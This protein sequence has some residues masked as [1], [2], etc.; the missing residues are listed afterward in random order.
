MSS[1]I[2]I[3]NG[4]S[5]DNLPLLTKIIS[6][7]KSP[8]FTN[9]SFL[10]AIIGFNAKIT[11]IIKSELSKYLKNIKLLIIFLYISII[12]LFLNAK[13]KLSIISF[14]SFVSVFNLYD[15]NFNILLKS[16]CGIFS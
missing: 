4:I 11:L 16:D 8:S 3:G 15:K 6:S 1:F 14:L 13:G 5:K 2:I 7:I 10:T 9:L 12:N